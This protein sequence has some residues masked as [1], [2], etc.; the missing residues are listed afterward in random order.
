MGAPQTCNISVD[1]AVIGCLD[2]AS[3]FF[4]AATAMG[5]PRFSAAASRRLGARPRTL[6][7]DAPDLLNAI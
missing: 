5:H 4:G 6:R 2:A 7:S 1:V 3:K